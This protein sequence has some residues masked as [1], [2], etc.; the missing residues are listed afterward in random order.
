M[1]ATYQRPARCA[2]LTILKMEIS[3]LGQAAFKLKG[4][5]A[6]VVTD[7]FNPDFIGL[8]WP[9]VEADIVSISHD[10]GDHNYAGGVSGATYT[11]TGPGEYEI[12]GVAFTGTSSFHD[13]KQGAERGKNTIFTFNI[14]GVRICHLGDLGQA[15][16]S[17]EQLEAIGDVDVL[18]IPVG[19]V[20]T[21]DGGA[22]AKIV[23]QI[24]PKVIIPMHYSQPGLKVNL[25]P[26]DHFLKE[27]GKE[28]MTPAAKLSVSADKLPEEAEVVVLEKS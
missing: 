22:A 13:N 10:H 26:V 4:K 16:L 3:W 12:K 11:A 9:K 24:E 19:S 14:D 2:G 23:A 18:L 5:T 8:K 6:T 1:L 7:P 25:E 15:Q 20:Y 21:I 27:M 28:G 17:D